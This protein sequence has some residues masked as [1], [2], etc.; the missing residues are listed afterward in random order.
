MLLHADSE[1]SDQT[2]QMPR[3]IGVF[4]G[5]TDHFVG[6][7]RVSTQMICQVLHPCQ[8]H[9]NYARLI[10]KALCKRSAALG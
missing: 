6:F 9:F 5:H 4:A 1:V 8:Q 7:F 3:L 10:L 2:G